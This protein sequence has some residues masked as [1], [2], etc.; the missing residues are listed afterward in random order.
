MKK[1]EKMPSLYGTVVALLLSSI[2][3]FCLF[4]AVM[5]TMHAIEN[6]GRLNQ[7]LLLTLRWFEHIYDTD[8]QTP[9]QEKLGLHSNMMFK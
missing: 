3:A 6:G 9:V 5:V 8:D 1:L 7:A 4:V 2:G